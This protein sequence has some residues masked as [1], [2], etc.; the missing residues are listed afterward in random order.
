M[1]LQHNHSI[2][3]EDL[4]KFY[5]CG[6]FYT[7][8]PKGLQNKVCFEIILFFCRQGRENLRE[9]QKDSFTFGEESSGRRYNAR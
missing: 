2:S 6:I 4:K 8:D 9:L 5:N 7:E 3:K 1:G